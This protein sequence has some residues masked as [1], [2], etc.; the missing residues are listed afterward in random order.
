MRGCNTS[1]GYVATWQIM[2]GPVLWVEPIVHQPQQRFHIMF[3]WLDIGIFAP[4]KQG[5]E[6][7]L[8]LWTHT[9]HVSG[10]RRPHSDPKWAHQRMRC[11]QVEGTPVRL[12]ADDDALEGIGT[13]LVVSGPRA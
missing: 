3:S 6:S 8:A 10:E 12:Q 9:P 2:G 13:Y 5:V 11:R 1:G 7:K 4:E